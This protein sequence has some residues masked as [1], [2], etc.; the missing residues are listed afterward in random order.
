MEGVQSHH[1]LIDWLDGGAH[2]ASFDELR[3]LSEDDLQVVE[4]SV[5]IGKGFE[6]NL[7]DRLEF[8][9]KD[10]FLL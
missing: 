3:V 9:F 5:T 7:C 1:I 2:S 6:G 10:L 4:D 8:F